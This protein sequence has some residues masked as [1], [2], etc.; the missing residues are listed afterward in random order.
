MILRLIRSLVCISVIS[1]PCLLIGSQGKIGNLIE[2]KSQ[3]ETYQDKSTNGKAIDRHHYSSCLITKNQRIVLCKEQKDS[4]EA[5]QEIFNN[6]KPNMKPLPLPLW[7]NCYN[8]AYKLKHK[9]YCES[10]PSIIISEQTSSATARYVTQPCPRDHVMT[11]CSVGPKTSYFYKGT[12][13]N[14]EDINKACLK[15]NSPITNTKTIKSPKKGTPV[16]PSLNRKAECEKA[17]DNHSDRYFCRDSNVS[18][19]K[20]K[21]CGMFKNRGDK[22]NCIDAPIPVDTLINCMSNH[23]KRRDR[24]QC[25]ET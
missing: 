3:I 5:D 22:V 10:L 12:R 13:A 21:Y 4:Q 25:L 11:S 14:A 16:V 19:E 1:F 20:I 24:I 23:S 15:L 9:S 17:F 6:C 18:I 8:A 7:V 2:S